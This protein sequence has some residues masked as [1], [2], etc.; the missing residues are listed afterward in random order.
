MF[1]DRYSQIFG[2]FGRTMMN[3]EFG[4]SFFS[5]TSAYLRIGQYGGTSGRVLEVAAMACWSSKTTAATP[6]RE[7]ASTA[8]CTVTFTLLI[9]I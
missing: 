1:P 4:G 8:S 5:P 6:H 2:L 3:C 7:G 9:C